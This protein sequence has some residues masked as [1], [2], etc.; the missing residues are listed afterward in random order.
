MPF[1]KIDN[2]R[3]QL[4]D[5]LSKREVIELSTDKS[6]KIL[7]FS[8]P[9]KNSTW[10]IL[11]DYF[12]SHRNDVQLRAYGFY[13]STCDLQFVSEMTNVS[14]FSADCLRDAKFVESIS[15]MPKLKSL[16]IGIYNLTDFNFL[17]DISEEIEELGL[18]ATKSKKP[19]LAIIAKFKKLKKLYLEGQQKNIE[20]IS[21]L[22]N[23]E[24][25][26]LRS[27]ST[28]TLDY[29]KSLNKLWSLGIK[30]GGIKDFSALEENT[31]IKYL[32]LWQIRGLKDLSFISKM[33]GLQLLFLQSLKNLKGLPD[34]KNCKRLR[35]IYLE[36]LK[37]LNDIHP[38][39][40][41]PALKELAYFEA[42]QLQPEDLIPA[43]ENTGLNSIN[44]LFGSEKKNKTFEELIK[45]YGK[46]K[47]Q[48]NEFQ[49]L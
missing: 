44:V 39:K 12:F 15:K 34:F 1:K 18:E 47:Y 23:L 29:I 14:H 11:N 40:D 16:N 46:H 36:N 37:E 2:S 42:S 24:D 38:L 21:E 35:R 43:L 9:I 10:S 13:G 22:T 31:S 45:N 7:Q 33:Y 4:E 6:V 26:T 25:L 17:S 5:S 3:H 27:I 32:E 20:V 8:N 19:D 48:R 28:P 30:L 41:A 49:Y